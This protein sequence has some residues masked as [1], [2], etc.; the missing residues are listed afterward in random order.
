MYLANALR[1]DK[2]DF[3]V[4]YYANCCICYSIS[5]SLPG[6]VHIYAKK[7]LILSYIQSGSGKSGGRTQ[8]DYVN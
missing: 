7:A 5:N 8:F 3:G 1:K 2:K 4:L 6:I